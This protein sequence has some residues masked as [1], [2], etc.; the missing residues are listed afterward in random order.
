VWFY[1]D[2]E[3]SYGIRWKRACRDAR[4]KVDQIAAWR[5]QRLDEGAELVSGF[6]W[7]GELRCGWR[8]LGDGEPEALLSEFR[9]LAAARAL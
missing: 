6:F 9:V 7:A 3:G 2:Q 4:C 8:T 5:A 1:R